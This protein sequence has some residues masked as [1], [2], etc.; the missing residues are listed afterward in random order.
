M[1]Y[2]TSGPS[3]FQGTACLFYPLPNPTRPTPELVALLQERGMLISDEERARRKLSQIGYY[4]LS[5]FWY[6]CRKGAVDESGAYVKDLLTGLPL[7]EDT[8]QDNTRFNEI[9]DLY[10]F[11]KK[12][13]QLMLD[14]IERIEIHVRSVIA[15][16]IGRFDPLA[17]LDTSFINPKILQDRRNK[18]GQVVN[19]WK[20]WDTKQQEL[21]DNSK[22]ECIVWH[23]KSGRSVPFWVVIETWDFGIM[24]KYFENLKGKYQEK[25]C[26]RLDVPNKKVL[27]GWLQEINILRNHCA[28]HSRIWN[29]V[30]SNSLAVLD[31]DYFKALG[32]D[33]EARK[34][35]Y[36]KICVLWYLVQRIG[37]NSDWIV[38]VAD[39][40]DSKPTIACC[41][42][43]SMGLPDNSGFPRRFFP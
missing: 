19:F 7:R 25:I 10:L 22:E 26:H 15:H 17:Y 42:Y 16:E 1:L 14:A 37:P 39:L 12:L 38:R 13:R 43:T 20:V 31:N 27:A 36:G 33:S 23:K 28:H 32:L 41:P 35:I 6:P 3:C 34:R 21:V 30:A 11:D 29:R 8:F 5:G 4:R 40:V 2:T 24:S 18:A 9:I